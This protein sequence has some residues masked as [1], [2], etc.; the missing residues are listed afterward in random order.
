MRSMGIDSRAWQGVLLSAVLLAIVGGAAAQENPTPVAPLESATATT[1]FLLP[2]WVSPTPDETGAIVVIVQ[3]GESL[4]VIAARA[5]VTLPDLLALNGL[6]EADI[7]NPGDRLIIGYAT[8][9]PPLSP[10]ES[11]P[12]AT[13][14]PPTL[15]PTETRAEAAIC[16]SAYDDLDRDG[17][18]DAGE[19][20]RAGVAFTVYNRET[21][22]ANTITDGQAE[23][24]CVRG[25]PPGE[26]RVTRSI[27][28]GEILTTDGNWALSLTAGSELRQ[29]FGSYFGTAEAALQ[30]GAAPVTPGTPAASLT[31]TPATADTRTAAS[32]PPSW[33]SVAGMLALFA[34]G[35]TLLGAVLILLRRQSGRPQ[36]SSPGPDVADGERRFRNID[37]LE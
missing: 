2:D 23:T 14:P 36:V 19:P 31:P 24:K 10:E 22:V 33:L 28:P 32:L 26:Y 8:P 25:L 37:D 5:G 12:T 1:P 3:P 13:R 27:S 18:E 4:W 35:L 9:E 20:Q 15:R 11:T 29:S 6:T 21:V 16:L 17:V 30:G 34:G 7:I